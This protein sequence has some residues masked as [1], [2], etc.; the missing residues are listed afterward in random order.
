ML[1][2]SGGQSLPPPLHTSHLLYHL[3]YAL[4]GTLTSSIL[5]RAAR[6][7]AGGRG[8]RL[9]GVGFFCLC[10][11][12]RFCLDVRGSWPDKGN[13]PSCWQASSLPQSHGNEHHPPRKTT[14]LA[15]LFAA[16]VA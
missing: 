9:S 1:S 11:V 3:S 4:Q 8:E 13:E 16:C 10:L 6:I 2:L 14:H 12:A 15:R 7:P 5:A